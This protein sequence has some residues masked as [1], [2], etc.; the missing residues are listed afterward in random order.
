MPYIMNVYIRYRNVT[1]FTEIF[2]CQFIRC[3][4]RIITEWFIG[5]II[6]CV[7]YNYLVR[8][9][10]FVKKWRIM[11]CTR[12]AHHTSSL[13]GFFVF[14]LSHMLI[15]VLIDWLDIL[16][17]LWIERKRHKAIVSGI[18][19]PICTQLHP[20]MANL[21]QQCKKFKLHVHQVDFVRAPNR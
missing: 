15:F 4:D 18:F 3:D 16:L 14:A 19:A 6:T 11:T 2:A 17:T 20:K 1:Y 5:F 21:R 9:L 7:C 13:M 12:D 8:K 10:A